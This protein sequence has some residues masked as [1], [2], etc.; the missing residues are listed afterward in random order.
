MVAYPAIEEGCVD[1]E[2]CRTTPLPSLGCRSYR[3]GL[4]FELPDSTGGSRLGPTCAPA[5][6]DGQFLGKGAHLKLTKR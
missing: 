6:S 4:G 2:R 3:V 5:I 1:L